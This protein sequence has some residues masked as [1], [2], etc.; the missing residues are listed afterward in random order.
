MAA[1]ET[2]NALP[3]AIGKKQ[4]RQSGHSQ[5]HN[6]GDSLEA[7]RAPKTPGNIGEYPD[8]EEIATA[9][10]GRQGRPQH[11]S[12]RV[13]VDLNESGASIGHCQADTSDQE[14]TRFDARP[15]QVVRGIEKFLGQNVQ[16]RAENRRQANDYEL[17]PPARRSDRRPKGVFQVHQDPQTRNEKDDVGDI[18]HRAKAQ[19]YLL[20]RRIGELLPE[21][22]QQNDR[23][24]RNNCNRDSQTRQGFAIVGSRA[25]PG[26]AESKPDARCEG[27][28]DQS[29]CQPARHF[30]QLSS[31]QAQTREEALEAEDRHPGKEVPPAGGG[32]SRQQ[33]D[34]SRGQA[35]DR[36]SPRQKGEKRHSFLSMAGAAP[37]PGAAATIKA[38]TGEP[39]TARKRRG[40]LAVNLA[41]D[42]IGSDMY[43]KHPDHEDPEPVSQDPERNHE[44]HQHDPPPSGS[45]KEIGREQPGDEQHPAGVDPAALR[46]TW[47]TIPGSSNTVPWR[48]IGVPATLKNRAAASA[49]ANIEAFSSQSTAASGSGTMKIRNATGKALAAIHLAPRNRNPP[50][51]A[52]LTNARAASPRSSLILTLWRHTFPATSAANPIPPAVT[53][54]AI[55]LR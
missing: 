31:A 34:E 40:P 37:A 54:P 33:D 44:G 52:K 2:V 24:Q 55:E 45:Q 17:D 11:G 30:G 41:V 47:S 35:E 32:A 43:A 50:A 26:Q 36:G 6:E 5:Q 13:H 4:H 29:R 15:A 39:A 18:G 53:V 10:E 14:R 28:D 3:Q 49:D 23:Q 25:R 21:S 38:G 46:A 27:L 8:D 48:T 7:F 12:R 19:M 20:T 22:E 9:D 51:A 1:D 16:A 42:H